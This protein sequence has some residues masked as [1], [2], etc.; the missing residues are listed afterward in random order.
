[1]N[2]RSSEEGRDDAPPFTPTVEGGVSPLGG[3]FPGIPVNYFLLVDMRRVMERNQQGLIGVDYCH[4]MVKN[5][6]HDCLSIFGSGNFQIWE[7]PIGVCIRFC[8]EKEQLEN[9]LKKTRKTARIWGAGE[10]C[11]TQYRSDYPEVP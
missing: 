9:F 4:Y 2:N 8:C 5:V 6:L 11:L 3:I 7:N 10:N 1:M